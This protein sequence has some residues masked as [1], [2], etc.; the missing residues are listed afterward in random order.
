MVRLGGFKR[1]FLKNNRY[2]SSSSLSFGI[3]VLTQPPN[4][5]T[6]AY[7]I[8]PHGF[9]HAARAA[10][11]MNALSRRQP[12][13]RFEIFTL[14]PRWFFE[15]SVPAPFTYHPLLTD[16]GLAQET[17]LRE[18]VPLT[19]KRLEEFLPF[20]QSLVSN[21][22]SRIS[23]CDLVICDIAPLGIAVARA[24]GIPSVLIENFTWDW[25][26]RGYVHEDARFKQP[27]AYLRGVFRSADHH[28]Q[29][30]PV[31]DYWNA[32]L[33]TP[34]V[35]RAPRTSR[36]AMREQMRIPQRAKTVLITMG[37]I[38]GRHSFLDR[39]LE[40]KNVTFILAGASRSMRRQGNLILLPHR[41]LLYHPD[42]MNAAD[43]AIGKAGYST[44]AEVYHVGIP[45]GFVLRDKFRESATMARFIK[46]QMHGIEISA[47]QFESGEWLSVLPDLLAL[48]RIHRCE[49]NGAEQ[50]ARFIIDQGNPKRPS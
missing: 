41:S 42:V 6:I 23:K 48:P 8:S 47:A 44:V 4:H 16:I 12:N 28:I 18:N 35:S 5:S 27:I 38:P 21:L 26:Y 43:A 15:I 24:A 31:C 40:I 33:V 37:G 17:S 25:I 50:A 7:F 19:L 10:A 46:K 34:P 2:A 13:I 30:E 20:D 9:G 22:A 36:Q 3:I 39:L 45:F 11:V 14:V 1:L 32:D 29:T 49:A